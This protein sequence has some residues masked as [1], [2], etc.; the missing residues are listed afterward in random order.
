MQGQIQSPSIKVDEIICV[1]RSWKVIVRSGLLSRKMT[2][3]K[4]LQFCSFRAAPPELLLLSQLLLTK[5]RGAC[6]RFGD[7]SCVDCANLPCISGPNQFTNT[8]LTRPSNKISNLLLTQ[9]LTRYFCLFV[10]R[11]HGRRSTDKAG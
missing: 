5:L 11:G 9:S 4:T 8:R 6:D 2:V 1:L 3:D 10:R 7:C